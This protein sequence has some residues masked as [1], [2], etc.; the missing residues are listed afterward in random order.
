MFSITG[1]LCNTKFEVMKKIIMSL[2]FVSALAVAGLAQTREKL[3]KNTQ[4]TKTVMETS[5]SSFAAKANES[6]GAATTSEKK[7]IIRP[8][9]KHKHHKKHKIK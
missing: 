8:K 4:P 6:N 5:T 9:H 2:L 7:E 3:L 1:S